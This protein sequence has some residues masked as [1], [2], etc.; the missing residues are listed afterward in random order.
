M[1]TITGGCACG[2][3]RYE[4]S[5]DP[6]FQVACHCRACQYASGGAPTLAALVPKAAFRITKGEA[7]TYWSDGDSGAQVGR[8]FCAECGT[9][10]FSQPAANGDIA[11]I[12]VGGLD[13]PSR[14]TVQANIYA[15][16]A[17]PW[18]HMAEGVPRFETMPG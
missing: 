7:K 2:A 1:T 9:P 3:V 18:H 15:K 8:S 14:F 10:L 13:D 4:I 12:K 11:V 5:A 6:I 16:A 17:Q